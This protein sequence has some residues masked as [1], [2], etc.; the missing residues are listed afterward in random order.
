MS[1]D[2][3]LEE[4]GFDDVYL[5]NIDNFTN[6]ANTP[7]E[8]HFYLLGFAQAIEL[9]DEYFGEQKISYKEAKSRVTA[10]MEVMIANQGSSKKTPTMGKSKSNS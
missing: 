10:I 2:N 8:R 6:L 4:F 1:N 7:N 5:V 9:Y 3:V